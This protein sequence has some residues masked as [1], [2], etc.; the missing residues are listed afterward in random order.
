MKEVEDVLHDLCW[1]ELT[2]VVSSFVDP[3][4]DNDD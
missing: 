1:K 2:G 3:D 4:G